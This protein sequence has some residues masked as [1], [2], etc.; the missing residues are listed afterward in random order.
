MLGIGEAFRFIP[1]HGRDIQGGPACTGGQGKVDSILLF[2][3][4]FSLPRLLRPGCAHRPVPPKC[5]C[6]PALVLDHNYL[7]MVDKQN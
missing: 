5:L 7:V 3:L 1:G 4:S 6:N 2:I